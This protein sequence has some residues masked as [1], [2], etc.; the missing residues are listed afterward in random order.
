MITL[1]QKLEQYTSIYTQL[2]GELKWKTS[3]SRTGMMIAA[4]YA[5][6]DKPF[7]LGR[8]LEISNYIKDQVGM[9]SYLKSYHRFVVAATLDIH[10]THY[11]E[12][13]QKFLDLYER[14]VAGGFSQSIFTY[15][16][17]AALLPED[18]GQHDT[19]I[20]RSM[21][22]YKRMKDD[23]FFLTSANDYPLAVLLAG[24]QEKVETLMDR[25]E[26]FYQKLAAAGMRKGNDLQFLSHIL[27]LKKDVSE[28]VLV[29]RYINIWNMMK[30]EKVK[31][32]Q[33]HYPAIGLL[34]LLEDGE[35]EVHSIRAFIEK[36]Q[37]DKLFRWHTD[38]NILIAIQ[39]FVSQ[40]G[41]E[42]QAANTG[43]QTMIEVLIQAQQAAMI[44]AIT[45]STAAAS[46]SSG[47]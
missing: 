33:M 26:R 40:K 29:A 23:H 16:A 44:A 38:A 45:A 12:A 20:Q 14:L 6:G 8:F 18:N 32:K 31:V 7:N 46:A 24:Q 35:K 2:K 25:V 21:Q 9:F 15:L 36:L 43:L 5:G 37:G 13:F 30:Q 22:V 34:A 10:F 4:M 39:L 27:S 11:K 3:D 17:A 1:Q 28:D 42:S 19:R 41:A 47:S